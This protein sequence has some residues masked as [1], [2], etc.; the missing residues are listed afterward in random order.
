[1]G[2]GLL[3]HFKKGILG[4]LA[5]FVNIPQDIYFFVAVVG[6]D[7]A[8]ENQFPQGLNRIGLFRAVGGKDCNVRMGA[9]QG[10]A[11]G[12]AQAAGAPRLLA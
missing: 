9:R 10:K 6:Q 2:R 8:A 11:A 12:P 7:V 4:L 1:M 3:Y 5:H